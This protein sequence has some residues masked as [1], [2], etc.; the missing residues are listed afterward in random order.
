MPQLGQSSVNNLDAIGDRPM[1]RS[2]YRTFADGHESLVGNFTVSSGGVAGVRWYELRGVTSGP[3]TTFQE[4]TY[5][6]DTTWRFQGS[7]AMDKQGNMALGFSASSSAI[8]PQVRY[9]GRLAGD[10]LNTLPQGEATMFAGTGAQTGTVNRWGDYSDMTID[11]VDDCTF[12]YTTEYYATTTSFNWRTRIGN[13]KFPGCGAATGANLVKAASRLTHGPGS[14]P[15]AGTFD[16]DMPLAGTS[17]VEDR[18]GSSSFLAVFTFDTPV[19][20]GNASIAGGTATAGTPTFSGNEMQVPLTGVADIQTVTIHIAGVNGGNATADVPFSFLIGDIDGSRA[21][22]RGDNT[23]LKATKGQSA[24]SNNFRND[25]D[26][27][28]VVDRPDVTILKAS[29]GH[30]L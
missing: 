3:V 17:G 9:T 12:W 23:S 2:A 30:S 14:A 21:V 13:F 1:F 15:A 25:L 24:D 27:N 4:A 10:P 22:D 11:P 8:F 26:L 19:T 6:P 18:D 16:V 29:K 28:G 20:S 5:Q 7:T